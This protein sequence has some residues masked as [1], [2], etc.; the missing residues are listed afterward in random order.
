MLRVVINQSTV[1]D[2]HAAGISPEEIYVKKLIGMFLENVALDLTI[3]R[4]CFD[5]MPGLMCAIIRSSN[6]IY[7]L[8]NCQ[9]NQLLAMILVKHKGNKEILGLIDDILKNGKN[10]VKLR[11]VEILANCTD[12]LFSLM[13]VDTV[14]TQIAALKV[15]LAAQR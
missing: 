14:V 15:I 2:A 11:V 6:T 1:P 12:T 8:E 7:I 9:L 10:A 5:H 4:S 3:S 13:H